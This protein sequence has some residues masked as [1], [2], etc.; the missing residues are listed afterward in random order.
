MSVQLFYS[1][2]FE[3]FYDE[4]GFKK[5]RIMHLSLILHYVLELGPIRVLH[6]F[7]LL[8]VLSS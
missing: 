2:D 3:L 8:P 7:L 4:L 1:G 6:L 5:G